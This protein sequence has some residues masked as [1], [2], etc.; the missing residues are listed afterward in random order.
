MATVPST[1]ELEVQQKVGKR[2]V[3]V[4]QIPQWK[5][6]VGR[7]TR[8]KLSVG[9]GIVLI[10]MYLMVIFADF[11]APYAYDAINSDQKYASPTPI[12]FAGGWPAVYA[13][14]ATLDQ[15]TFSWVYATDYSKTFPVKFFVHGAE[16][17]L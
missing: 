1:A 7:F 6:M 15:K 10:I 11:L 16:Y 5:L 2:K 3:D 17:K 12:T 13:K 14:T 9:G 4:G 8:S